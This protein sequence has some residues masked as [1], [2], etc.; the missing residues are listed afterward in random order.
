MIKADGKQLEEMRVAQKLYVSC[1][2]DKGVEVGTLYVEDNVDP[3]YLAG[4]YLA[5]H[6]VHH[7]TDDLSLWLILK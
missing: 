6:V 7:L 4:L 5:K 3:A 2:A 1:P